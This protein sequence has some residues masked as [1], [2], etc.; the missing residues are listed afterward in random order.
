MNFNDRVEVTLTDRGRLVLYKYEI[1]A[2]APVHSKYDMTGSRLRMSLWELMH[3]FG[4]EM[5]MGSEPCF[6][7]NELRLE[8]K[9]D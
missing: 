9:S 6:E 8:P 1:D 2:G 5:T 4:P 7:Q 3:V